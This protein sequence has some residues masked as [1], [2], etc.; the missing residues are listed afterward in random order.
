MNAITSLKLERVGQIGLRITL[1]RAWRA[2]RGRPGL[3]HA[4]GREQPHPSLRS[5]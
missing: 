5:V 4:P 3:L 1:P 2:S